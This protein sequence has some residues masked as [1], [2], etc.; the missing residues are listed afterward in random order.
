[1]KGRDRMLS[2]REVAMILRRATALQE[3]TG[4]SQTIDGLSLET[5][6]EIAAEI[7][8]D[9]RF[10]DEAAASVLNVHDSRAASLMGGV[11]REYVTTSYDGVLSARKRRSWWTGCGARFKTTGTWQ[12]LLDRPSGRRTECRGWL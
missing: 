7:G 5:V 12:P 3:E 8:V 9:R 11:L 4:G 6:R 10:V 2:D 1:M